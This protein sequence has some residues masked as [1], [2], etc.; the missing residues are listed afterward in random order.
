LAALAAT[1]LLLAAGGIVTSRDAGM[2]FPDWPLSNGSLN[3]E[4]WLHDADKMSEH[5]HRILGTLV[6]LLSIWLAVR[7]QRRE[8]R[9]WVRVLGW[10]AL[11]AVVLQGLLGGLRVLEISG[12]LALVHGCTGQLFFCLMVLLAYLTSSDAGSV[13]EPG[14]DARRLSVLGLA[15]LS[16]VLLQVALGAQ[17]RHN[18][19]PI[20][21]HVLGALLSAGTVFWVLAG[22]ALRH[23]ARRPLC[24]PALLLAALLLLQVG[25]GILA[26]R[27]LS[28][29]RA[30]GA[31]ALALVLPS[32]HQAVGGLLLGCITWLT[33]K[34]IRRSGRFAAG[35]APR[36]PAGGV[37]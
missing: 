16:A 25:L 22:V 5:G 1:F 24:R 11:G 17:L 21:A 13:P 26:A 27:A 18:L 8:R 34:A 28:D 9:R 4:G 15:A 31:Q 35:V 29:P 19:G 2:V 33:A 12:T 14:P 36:P 7:L 6:G 32:L 37:R 10:C 20:D 30:L 3:P 23:G